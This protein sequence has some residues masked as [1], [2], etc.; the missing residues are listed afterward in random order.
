MYHEEQGHYEDVQDAQK[1]QKYRCP[2]CGYSAPTYATKSEYYAH[3]DSAHRD[4]LNSSFDRERYEMVSDWVYE[5]VTVW[6]VDQKAYTE[7]IVTGR[8]CTICEMAE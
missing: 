4:E 2:R 1:V 6:V 3:F 5:T 7:T 8:K